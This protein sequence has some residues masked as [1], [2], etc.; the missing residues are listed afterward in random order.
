MAEALA[1]GGVEPGELAGPVRRSGRAETVRASAAVGVKSIAAYRTGLDL[2][3]APP[4][5]AEV[6]DAA[7]GW[8]GVRLEHPV[9]VRMTLAA[10]VEL[11]LPIQ[12]HIGF[13]DADIRM[14]RVDPT[15]LTDWL[16][17]APGAGHAAALL[18]V[19]AAGLFLAAVHPHVHLDVGLAAALRRADP[20]PGVLAEAA[21]VAPFGKLLYS[22][23]A[24]GLPELYHLGALTFRRALAAPLTHRVEAGE[25]S[26]ADATGIAGLIG[27]GNASAGYGFP[28]P[29]AIGSAHGAEPR[30]EGPPATVTDADRE[31]AAERLADAAGAGWLDPVGISDRVAAV[32][33]A[34]TPAQLATATAGIE[35]S[36]LV[37]T[38]RTVSRVVSVMGDSRR[39]GRWRLPRRLSACRGRATC[40]ST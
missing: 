30:P 12:F 10:A 39:S 26:A 29:P 7:A 4:A 24:Y 1:A 31:A 16:H 38:T 17:T 22:S 18:A 35:L 28:G 14:S 13:G 3:P 34:D 9:L 11:G 32:R 23:D 36:P 20:R 21:E 15:L 37:G 5:P 40:T 8:D 33:A 27:D 6:A 2:D 25:W 19:P